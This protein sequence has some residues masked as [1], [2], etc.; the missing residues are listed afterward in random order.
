M[1]KRQRIWVLVGVCMFWIM[2]CTS[3][4]QTY[5]RGWIG[6][7]YLESN[8]SFLKGMY[9]NYFKTNYGVIPAL[10]E[11]IKQQQTSAVLVTRVYAD[12]P[13]MKAGIEEGDLII[14]I[15]NE[16]VRNVKELRDS[17]EKSNP[18]T[19]INVSIYRNGSILNIPVVVGKETYE[20]WHSIELG[21]RLGPELDPIP[22]PEF[23]ILNIVSYK[24]NDTRLELQ[25]SEY[26]Y[27][28]SVSPKPSNPTEHL[29]VNSEG[30]DAWFVILGLSGN[31]LI[32][33][34]EI[35]GS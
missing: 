12:T 22:H 26:R 24:I 6:G 17:V 30:W 4:K 3:T 27:Y 10:P 11:E 18:G 35:V 23:S 29:K 33:T 14:G 28:Q 20:K 13:I 21:L 16:K 8:S 15:N 34:Q 31:K 9:A 25:S 7:K 2:G 1:R 19:T 5:Q 32:L